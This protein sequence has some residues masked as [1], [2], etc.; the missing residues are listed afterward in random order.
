[1][2]DFLIF[3]I[4]SELVVYVVFSI[5]FKSGEKTPPREGAP[6]DFS[7]VER[8]RLLGL[9]FSLFFLYKRKSI[10]YSSLAF[11]HPLSFREFTF[12]PL[13]YHFSGSAHYHDCQHLPKNLWTGEI[14]HKTQHALYPSTMILGWPNWSQ[15]L[16]RAPFK[17]SQRIVLKLLWWEDF[18]HYSLFSFLVFLNIKWLAVTIN[19]SFPIP[20][21]LKLNPIPSQTGSFIHL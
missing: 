4:A 1:M 11:H 18:I 14:C 16:L 15:I 3:Y 10:Y 2:Y 13:P 5:L 6:W 19:S 8:N 17:A 20:Y 21:L 7:A 12:P 9:R